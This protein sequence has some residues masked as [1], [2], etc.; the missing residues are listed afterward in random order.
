MGMEELI[1]SF[2]EIRDE[3]I[4]IATLENFEDSTYFIIERVLLE[5]NEMESSKEIFNTWTS[6]PSVSN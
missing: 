4:E 3:E 5:L 6:N 1:S 2:T